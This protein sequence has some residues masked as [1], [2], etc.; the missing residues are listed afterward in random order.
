MQRELR[1]GDRGASPPAQSSPG[2]EGE[3]V[4][5]QTIPKPFCGILSN[6]FF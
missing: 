5:S 1:G 2:R 3:R 6:P 4:V